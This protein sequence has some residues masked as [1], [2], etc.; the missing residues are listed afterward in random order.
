MIHVRE[1]HGSY[2]TLHAALATPVGHRLEEGIDHLFIIDEIQKAESYVFLSVLAVD[3]LIDNGGDAS[4]GLI[5]AI[6]HERLCLTELIGG[7]F[8]W[9]QCVDIVEDERGHEAVVAPVHVDAELYIF[10]QFALRRGNGLYSN[11]DFNYL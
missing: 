7:I 8:A 3:I 2:H 6:S 5:V 1:S 11:H 4:Y 10:F 9:E